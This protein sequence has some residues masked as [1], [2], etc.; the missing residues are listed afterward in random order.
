M[1]KISLTPGMRSNLL[2]LQNISGQIGITQNRLAT[3]KKVN[4]AIDNPI[5]FYTASSLNSRARDLNALL[6]AMGQS[7]SIVK[8]AIHGIKNGIKF[9]QQARSI[10]EQA[11]NEDDKLKPV[12]VTK[13]G[14]KDISYLEKQNNVFFFENRK[15]EKISSVVTNAEDLLDAVN[16]GISGDIVVLGDINMGNQSIILNDDQNLVG[17]DKYGAGN[18][19]QYSKLTFTNV[20]VGI[21]AGNNSTI[22]WLDVNVK[23][24]TVNGG[25]GIMVNAKSNVA[26]RN[27]NIAFHENGNNNIAGAAILVQNGSQV[28][29]YDTLNIKTTGAWRN[30]G[31]RYSSASTVDAY[32]AKINVLTTGSNYCF[33]AT[34]SGDGVMSMWGNSELNSKQTCN[35][36]ILT[37]FPDG[38]FRIMS[39]N[40]KVVI[41]NGKAFYGSNGKNGDG[42]ISVVKGA[43]FIINSTKYVAK[44]D[45][46]KIIMKT[47]NNPNS[48]YNKN[49][50]FTSSKATTEETADM[51][52]NIAEIKSADFLTNK[53]TSPEY[54]QYSWTEV[55][56]Q[57][58][59]SSQKHW[60]TYTAI[61]DQYEDILKDSSYLGT[62]LLLGDNQEVLFNEN[63]SSKLLVQGKSLRLSDIGINC[64][65]WKTEEDITNSLNDIIN[66]ERI[67]RAYEAQLGGHYQTIQTRQDFTEGLINILT[68]GAD[69]LTLADMNEEAA[70]VLAL[71]TRQQIAITTLSLVSQS[72]RAIFKLF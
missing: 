53:N 26:L 4:S 54:E 12:V 17:V 11:I 24:N 62:N 34:G 32:D 50:Q 44:N 15:G 67:L 56:Y 43:T 64:S 52:N 30:Y 21:E 2:S 42:I 19:Y 18:L 72:M 31:I 27:I 41:E 70:N 69:K 37:G 23:A 36:A 65:E 63:S 57:K 33:S 59:V 51:K 39:E 55:E 9:L 68:E 66:A 28:N 5:N 61:L 49:N 8:A 16:S 71:Q 6:D 29:L 1:S 13:Y 60:Q 45:A 38:N 58:G 20:D 14:Y 25:A 35:H 40:A 22:G 3:G 7:I 47:G 10:A 46:E 48:S